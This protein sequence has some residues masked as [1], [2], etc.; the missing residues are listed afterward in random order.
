MGSMTALE[1]IRRGHRVIGF[2]RFEPP[3][4]LGS[5]HGKTRIIREA[6]FEHPQYVPLVQRAYELWSQ[7]ERQCGAT[8]YQA[9]GGLMIG[10]PGGTLVAG[11]RRSAVEHRLPF[12]EAGPAE[13]RAR[14]PAF[15]LSPAEVALYEPRAG[16]LFPEKA[17]EAALHLARKAGAEL[18]SNEPVQE[19]HSEARIQVRTTSRLVEVDRLVIAAGAWMSGDLPGVSMPLSVA[20]QPLFWFDP[21]PEASDNLSEL[22]IFIWEWQP[23]RFFYGFPDL[24]DGMKAAI[25][26]EGSIVDPRQPRTVQLAE[27]RELASVMESRIPSVGSVRSAT[28][29]LYTNT[30]SGD[31]LLDRH[32]RDPRVV[33]ASPCSGHGF[34]F[35]PAIGEVLADLVEDRP[36][37]F[38]LSPFRLDRSMQGG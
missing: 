12:E 38:D 18:H 30:P 15:H 20:R 1:L 3:H 23:D 14:F 37:R 29:C 6:Y 16:V 8:L 25:H 33:L 4:D 2:D 11:A 9:T 36:P 28:T 10:P 24:G 19:W 34:K 27:S 22:P 13:T 21:K 26:H 35:S 31:F 32:P 17:I 7:L 5:S